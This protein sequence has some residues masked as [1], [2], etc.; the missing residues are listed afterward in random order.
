M[1]A[2][3]G[4]IVL[5]PE[6]FQTAWFEFLAGFVAFNT[7]IYVGLTLAKLIPWPQ[8]MRPVEVR[9][10]LERTLRR[11]V[12]PARS[13]ATLP[14]ATKGGPGTVSNRLPLA[15]SHHAARLHGVR[16]RG[17]PEDPADAEGRPSAPPHPGR[18]GGRP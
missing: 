7:L 8:V 6:V 17:R 3:A 4:G 2:Q 16:A 10:R 15:E 9:A 18:A 1:S 5:S 12:D 14:Q 13:A 11:P